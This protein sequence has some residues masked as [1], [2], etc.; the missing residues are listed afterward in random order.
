[1]DITL[2]FTLNYRK[3]W[4][5]MKANSIYDQRSPNNNHVLK[6]RKEK[7]KTNVKSKIIF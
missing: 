5:K 4:R 1:V 7:T 6:K 2:S 3:Q